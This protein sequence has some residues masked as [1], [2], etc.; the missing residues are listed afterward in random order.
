MWAARA[1]MWER[2]S[3][4]CYKPMVRGLAWHKCIDPTCTGTGSAGIIQ[5]FIDWSRAWYAPHTNGYCLL[6]IVTCLANQKKCSAAPSHWGG[7]VQACTCCYRT[8]SEGVAHV[9]HY[10]SNL[11][12]PWG[13]GGSR[14]LNSC[15]LPGIKWTV[16]AKSPITDSK[17]NIQY[18]NNQ[19]LI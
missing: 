18:T 3:I 5:K 15:R 14:V 16:I 8:K 4:S 7:F 9:V 10:Q 19:V 1:G 17:N 6:A 11:L 12:P 13:V 2:A